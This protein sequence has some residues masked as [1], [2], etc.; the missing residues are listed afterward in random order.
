MTYSEFITEVETEIRDVSAW[1]DDNSKL[2]EQ[3]RTS[4]V[5]VLTYMLSLDVTELTV[6]K[7]PSLSTLSGNA[8]EYVLPDDIFTH[9]P[10]AGI[11]YLLLDDIRYEPDDG[12]SFRLSNRMQDQSFFKSTRVFTLTED[13]I[14]LWVYNASDIKLGYVPFPEQPDSN[15]Y[16]SIELP[17]TDPHIQPVIELV[18]ARIYGKISDVYYQRFHQMWHQVYGRDVTPQNPKDIM[19]VDH[20]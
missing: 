17:F 19:E 6:K 13:P 12:C 18:A 1:P 2:G 3:I 11:R 5:M 8:N 9:L 16:S 14:S 20:G 15:T 7:S 10:K 4:Y